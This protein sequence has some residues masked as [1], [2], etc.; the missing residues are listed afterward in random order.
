MYEEGKGEKKAERIKRKGKIEEKKKG[1]NMKR[2][3]MQEK[4]KKKN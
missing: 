3:E 2:N 1:K 4:M